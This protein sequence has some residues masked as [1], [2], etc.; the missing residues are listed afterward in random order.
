[1]FIYASANGGKVL[2]ME[3]LK[4]CAICCKMINLN[5]EPYSSVYFVPH[6]GFLFSHKE[7]DNLEAQ[8]KIP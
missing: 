1:M 4:L 6:Q 3:Q 8:K 5:K 2:V 7:C